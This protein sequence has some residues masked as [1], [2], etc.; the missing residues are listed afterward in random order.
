MA[1]CDG[2]DR[3]MRGCRCRHCEEF[4]EYGTGIWSVRFGS[5][6]QGG[7]F[8]APSRSN[9]YYSTDRGYGASDYFVGSD[10]Q[11][12]AERPHVHVVHN[13]REGRI[14]FTVTQRD[15]SHTHTEYLPIDASGNEVNAVQ[16]RLR[17]QIF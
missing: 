8:P 1:L 5:G 16:E 3:P 15:G 11:I 4:F 6:A 12:T 7:G 13:P 14:I 2:E 17:R 9:G 10:G